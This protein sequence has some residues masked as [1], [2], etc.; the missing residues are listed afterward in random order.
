MRMRNL[1]RGDLRFIASSGILFVYVAFTVLYLLLLSIIP[2]GEPR[3]ITAAILTYTDP[4]A[5]G[6]F[7]MG[8]FLLLEKSQ[9][10]N[11]ALAVSPVTAGEYTFSKAVSLLVPGMAVGTILC[12]AGGTAGP[13][14]L[15]AIA[16][17][18]V[19]FSMAGLFVAVKTRSLNS[20]LIGVVPLEIVIC[21]PAVL[22]PFGLLRAA[23]WWVHPGV[24]AMR[25][26]LGQTEGWALC[27]AVLALWCFAA[28]VVCRKAVVRYFSELGGG[29]IL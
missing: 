27:L 13:A 25:L 29:R 22:Y 17:A 3:S 26:I 4:A 9:R 18:S 14:A 16:L 28:A 7:F 15:A 6:L 12:V 21:L 19:L 1:I 23:A 24:A 2:T 20:F 10:V 8:A 11:C 5:M